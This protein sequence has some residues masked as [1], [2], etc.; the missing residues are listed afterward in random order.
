MKTTFFTFC[1]LLI[2]ALYFPYQ[3]ASAQQWLT[4]GNNLVGGEFLGSLNSQPLNIVTNGT[5]RIY[6]T[7]TAGNVGIG[8]TAPAATAALDVSSITKGV[9]LPRMT[10]VQRDAI[11]TPATGLHI[12]NTDTKTINIY[13]G[14]NWQGVLIP[15]SS[16]NVGIGTVTPTTGKL[17]VNTG[18]ASASSAIDIRN[19]TGGLGNKA[20]LTWANGNYGFIDYDPASSFGIRYSAL[21]PLVFGNNTNNTYGTGTFTETMRITATGN[22]GIGTTGPAAILD[23]ASTTKG[24]LLP[25]MTTAQRNAIVSPAT[26]LLV[27]QT[28]GTPGFYYYRSGWNAIGA[29]AFGANT[30]LSNLDDSTAVNSDLLPDTTGTKN[31]GDTSAGWKNLYLTGDIY[32]RGNRYLS[33]VGIDNN[34]FGT[35]AGSNITSGTYN[36]GSGFQALFSNTNGYSNTADGFQSLYTNTGTYNTASGYQSLF[37]NTTGYAN[38]ASGA[39]ALYSNTTG[40]YN[41]AFGP[42]ALIGNT[43]GNSNTAVGLDALRNMN[44]TNYNTGIGY[45]AGE[46]TYGAIQGTFLGA[47]TRGGT[48]LSNVTAIGYGATAT[49][50]NQIMLG[51]AA[52]TSVKAAGSFVIYSDGRFKRDIKQDV[53]GLDFINKL[54]PVTYHYNIHDLNKHIDPSVTD[55]KKG[56]MKGKESLA[57]ESRLNEEAITQKEKKLYTG[58]IAQEVEDAAK[59]LNYD[60]SGIYKPA[61][62]KD[63]YGLSYSDFVVPLVKAVQELSKKNEELN[64]KAEQID[65]LQKEVA[66]LKEMVTRLANG[67]V[68]T[69]TN[70]SLNNITLDQ[71]N[72]NPF[73]SITSIPYNVPAGFKSAQLVIT[74]ASGKTFKSISLQKAGQGLVNLDATLLS[75]GAYNYTLIV[76]GKMITTRKMVVIK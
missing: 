45:Y 38:N 34:F 25:R 69:T 64:K 21:G 42:D 17:A 49:A 16:G 27:Y 61:N 63:V 19:S 7:P 23:I 66:D 59:K 5:S 58:F 1:V 71:N 20:A 48:G 65:L 35:S 31:L 11:V 2:S 36:T 6:V 14:T 70:N 40:S 24:V 39:F 60:F 12:Y 53:P 13:N 10:T 30:T 50:S 4:A 76:D 62:D 3:Q 52:V 43:T 22:V 74:D 54:R 68:L 29:S 9:L 46:N 28:D 33:S 18:V 55:T 72:P 41:T 67:Q 32:V 51:N 37:F 56:V 26:G 8:T 57:K 75:S 44:T 15:N 73:G 47:Q